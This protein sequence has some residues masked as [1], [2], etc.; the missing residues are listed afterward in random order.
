M[1]RRLYSLIL[2]LLLLVALTIPAFAEGMT[3]LYDTDGILNASEQ[4]TV[5]AALEDVSTRHGV[6]TAVV[7]TRSL[8]GWTAKDL[9]EG[10][11][12]EGLFAKDCIVFLMSV[13]EREWYLLTKGYGE[14]AVTDAGTDYL[15]EQMVP[16]LKNDAFAS[17][18]TVF[19]YGCDS[20]LTQAENGTPYSSKAGTSKGFNPGWIA[21]AVIVGAIAALIGTGIMKG[22]LKSV[23]AK[24][25]A[26]DY[27]RQGSLNLRASDEMF[28]RRQL[29]RTP[30]QRAT[31]S[32]PSG[33][34]GKSGKF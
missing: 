15:I 16:N 21:G 33:G 10:C 7:L 2:A 3:F 32:T 12:S 19:A 20:L 31:T 24:I 34:G 27:V 6:E 4:Q 26:A 25:E 1:K 5:S 22:K 11:Y 18:A 9:A 30:R 29:D 13:Q 17:A 23:H 8:D 28:I 14:L